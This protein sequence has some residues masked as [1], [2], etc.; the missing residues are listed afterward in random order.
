[1]TKD[2]KR[3]RKKSTAKQSVDLKKNCI[4]AGRYDLK[5]ITEEKDAIHRSTVSQST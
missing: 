4:F 1:M 5:K 3:K 2:N